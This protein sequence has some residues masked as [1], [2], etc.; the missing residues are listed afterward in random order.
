MMETCYT[1][2]KQTIAV[3]LILFASVNSSFSQQASITWAKQAGGIDID[4]GYDIFVAPDGNIY[5]VGAYYGSS[6]FGSVILQTPPA[7][8]RGYVSK[9]N[10]SGTVLW[11]KDFGNNVVQVVAA[12]QGNIYVSGYFSGTENF[13]G[14]SLTAT[15]PN[16]DLFVLKLNTNGDVLWAKNFQG[17]TSSAMV[18]DASGNIYL[19]GT[20]YGSTAFGAF[21]INTSGLPS[22]MFLAK[23]DPAGTALWAQKYGVNDE[24]QFRGFD[25]DANGNIYVTG[26]FGT[27]TTIGTSNFTAFGS[28]DIVVFKTDPTGTVTWAKQF[29]GSDVNKSSAI[30]VDNQGNTYLTGITKGISQFGTLSYTLAG[31]CAYLC[32][33]NPSGTPLWLKTYF[34]NHPISEESSVDVAID[35]AGNIYSTGQCME[36]YT[37]NAQYSID[38]VNSESAMYVLK[39]EPTNG[40][41][42]W[43]KGFEG[44]VNPSSGNGNWS[45][46]L[47]LDLAGNI[48]VCGTFYGTIDCNPLLQ[49]STN[50]YD[51]DAFVMKIGVSTVGI[52]ELAQNL[53]TVYPNP[54]NGTFQV[55]TDAPTTI[56]IT[57]AAGQ[58]VSTHHLKAEENTIELNGIESGVYFASTI[59]SNGQSIMQRIQIIR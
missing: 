14:I 25:I 6:L 33:L 12:P 2:F 23:L 27:S 45:S 22:D 1:A 32:K 49:T 42:I 26:I 3:G 47:D 16:Y 59:D 55:V 28:Y 58:L 10:A 8:Y 54:N 7:V 4:H 30:A 36:A 20:F 15:N 40:N 57:N 37:F 43:A 53:V 24:D 50:D 56:T 9:S 17:T 21:T 11:A 39:T 41:I 38:L 35:H 18:S 31:Y 46:S 5:S 34:T 48:F 51:Y 19:G 29:G 13:G 44:I 52:D